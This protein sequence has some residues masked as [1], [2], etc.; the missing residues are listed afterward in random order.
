MSTGSSTPARSSCRWRP[1]PAKRPDMSRDS[2]PFDPRADEESADRGG[3]LRTSSGQIAEQPQELPEASRMRACAERAVRPDREDVSH[4]YLLRGR[5]FR[6]CDSELETMADLGR[7]RVV[8]VADLARFV[9][10]DAARMEQDLRHLKR[11]GLVLDKTLPCSGRSSVRVAALSKTGKRL[12][13]ETRHVD[14]AQALY[15]GIVKVREAKHDT[16]LY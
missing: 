5:T 16:D 15:Y 8:A 10:G 12:L 13:R 14:A 7:F 6:L 11:Q 2:I 4:L 9:Y 1:K 3:D